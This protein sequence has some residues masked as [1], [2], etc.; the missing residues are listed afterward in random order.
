[1][2]LKKMQHLS[3]LLQ[4]IVQSFYRKKIDVS[5]HAINEMKIILVL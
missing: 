3:Q 2:L 4:L 5:K 1:M